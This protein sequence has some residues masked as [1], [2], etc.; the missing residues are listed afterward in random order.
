MKTSSFGLEPP[1]DDLFP[2]AAWSSQ[3]LGCPGLEEFALGAAGLFWH[4]A[5]PFPRALSPILGVV[6]ILDATAMG[7]WDTGKG[8]AGKEQRFNGLRLLRGQPRGVLGAWGCRV[9]GGV[10]AA[11]C[12]RLRS[13]LQPPRGAAKSLHPLCPSARIE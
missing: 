9:L 3:Q 10:A 13:F 5:A 6:R 12:R 2:E 7:P 4:P 1:L 8:G 11:G